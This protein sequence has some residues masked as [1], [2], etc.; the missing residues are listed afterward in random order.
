VFDVL[1]DSLNALTPAD[2]D[3]YANKYFTSERRIVTTFWGPGGPKPEGEAR[4]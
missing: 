3:A 4:Q 2:I 1:L